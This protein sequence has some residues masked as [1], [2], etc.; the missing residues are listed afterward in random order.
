MDVYIKIYTSG[1]YVGFLVVLA[2]RVTTI[3]SGPLKLL[4]SPRAFI[5][6]VD[7]NF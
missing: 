1:F 4:V 7:S 3:D 5:V 6:F 2:V